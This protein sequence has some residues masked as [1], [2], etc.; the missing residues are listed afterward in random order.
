M[1]NVGMFL[2]SSSNQRFLSLV[3]NVLAWVVECFFG[4]RAVSVFSFGELVRFPPTPSL[5][6]VFVRNSCTASSSDTIKLQE[7]E[8]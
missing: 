5:L 4:E 6:L 1:A 8:S 2:T 3:W 7:P